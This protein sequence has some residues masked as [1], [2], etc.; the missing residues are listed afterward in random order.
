MKHLRTTVLRLM[1]MMLMTFTL[2]CCN[3]DDEAMHSGYSL[4]GEWLGYDDNQGLNQR[5]IVRYNSD[6]TFSSD[7][8]VVEM[9]LNQHTK[10]S[11]TYSFDGSIISETYTT[12]VNGETYSDNLSVIS[13]TPTTLV[14]SNNIVTETKHRIVDTFNMQVGDAVNIPN[15]SFD[16][17]PSSYTSLEPKIAT[18]SSD[19]NI[20][21]IKRGTTYVRASNGTEAFNVRVVVTDP[22]NNIDDFLPYL[23]E[24]ISTVTAAMGEWFIT[25]TMNAQMDVLQYNLLD[26]IMENVGFVYKVDTK[27]VVYFS[28]DIREEVDMDK[29]CSAFADKYH[30]ESVIHNNSYTYTTSKDGRDVEIRVMKKER[31]IAYFFS[32]EFE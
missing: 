21:A 3:D 1:P 7:Y 28:I 31:F 8:W 18:V 25:E 26:D 6:G 14:V 24:N 23:G 17:I 27:Q 12:S 5:F 22:N 9:Q 19:G 4:V 13:L 20:R 16:F 32:D 11:G 2:S 10:N 30:L 29:I 15:Y